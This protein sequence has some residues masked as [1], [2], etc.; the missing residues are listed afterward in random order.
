MEQRAITGEE[1]T[2]HKCE[3]FRDHQTTHSNSTTNFQFSRSP[4]FSLAHSFGYHSVCLPTPKKY[5]YIYLKHLSLRLCARVSISRFLYIFS[6]L[7]PPP[8]PSVA[9]YTKHKLRQ[10]LDGFAC[11]RFSHNIYVDR[12]KIRVWTNAPIA[13]KRNS[14]S[15]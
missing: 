8:L 15:I 10:H 13:D 2:K 3:A 14:F 6:V 9:M 4:G 12:N 5:I 1:T 11:C 7:S